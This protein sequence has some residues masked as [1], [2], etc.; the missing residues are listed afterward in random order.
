MNE[1]AAASCRAALRK[2]FKVNYELKQIVPEEMGALYRDAQ[3]AWFS[4]MYAELKIVEKSWEGGS[5]L[6][7][8]VSARR[9]ELIKS[10]T[11]YLKS[12]LKELKS[13]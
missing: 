6:P 1:K 10:R 12:I 4:F 11:R 13:E 3:E 9:E 8:M 7:L 2:M 5:I